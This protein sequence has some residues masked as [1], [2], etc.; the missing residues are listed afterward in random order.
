MSRIPASRPGPAA[1]TLADVALVEILVRQARRQLDCATL[2]GLAL[3]GDETDESLDE[4][5]DAIERLTR[6]IGLVTQLICLM[7]EEDPLPAAPF[8]RAGAAERGPDL[9]DLLEVGGDAARAVL[10]IGA[11]RL[12]RSSPWAWS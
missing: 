8:H 4:T 12:G 1:G 5:I 11:V 7:Q 3:G 9:L 2:A 6:Q 10:D